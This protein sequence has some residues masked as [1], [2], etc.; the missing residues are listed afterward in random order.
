MTLTQQIITELFQHNAP[1]SPKNIDNVY[2]KYST[3]IR[4]P[5]FR[6]LLTEYRFDVPKDKGTLK[7][8]VQN[9]MPQKK[10]VKPRKP[11]SNTRA[12]QVLAYAESVGGEFTKQDIHR[13]FLGEFQDTNQA[14]YWILWN[15]LHDGK[16]ERI[17]RGKYKIKR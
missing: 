11:K 6:E 10:E 3:H 9:G 12:K 7:K 2:A 17:S 4:W 8:W 5:D 16:I 15:L 14:V 13:L 1:E